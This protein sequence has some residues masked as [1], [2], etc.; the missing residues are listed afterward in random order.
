[1]ADQKQSRAGGARG[2]GGG[3]GLTLPHGSRPRSM[4]KGSLE[5]ISPRAG[6]GGAGG[7]RLLSLEGTR[8]RGLRSFAVGLKRQLLHT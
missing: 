8:P 6:G 7:G 5:S 1:M 2:G 4:W 3:G